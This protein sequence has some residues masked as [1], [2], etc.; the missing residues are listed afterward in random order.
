MAEISEW[1]RLARRYWERA[2]ADYSAPHP[3]PQDLQDLRWIVEQHL[4]RTY[5]R[6]LTPETLGILLGALDAAQHME[7]K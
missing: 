6:Y 3:Q 5:R 1:L 4:V 7:P 2:V